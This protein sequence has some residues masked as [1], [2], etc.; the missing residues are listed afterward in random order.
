M[1]KNTPTIRFRVY[2]TLVAGLVGKDVPQDHAPS[3]KD[4]AAESDLPPSWMSLAQ[5]L[6][7]P[8]PETANTA[9]GNLVLAAQSSPTDRE[10]WRGLC[11][12]VAMAADGIDRH[13]RRVAATA[14]V[15]LLASP[16]RR[17][18]ATEPI[19]AIM[20]DPGHPIHLAA[21]A[22]IRRLTDAEAAEI[23]WQH[24]TTA[25]WAAACRARLAKIRAREDHEPPAHRRLHPL[26]F[27]GIV[28][29]ES[30][31]WGERAPRAA[32]L[33]EDSDPWSDTDAARIVARRMLRTN[34]GGLIE[35][36]AR[37]LACPEPAIALHAV[38]WTARLNLVREL[39]TDLC[40][41]ARRELA[42]PSSSP[43]A[44]AVAV[45]LRDAGDPESLDLLREMMRSAD[46]RL[47]ASAM[48]SLTRR[49]VRAGA[50]TGVRNDLVRF[51]EDDR[52]RVR[53]TAIWLWARP[54]PEAASPALLAMLTDA[55][56]MHRVAAL[57]ATERLLRV[58]MIKPTPALWGVLGVAAESD[59]VLAVRTRA[60][61]C[62]P[63]ASPAPRV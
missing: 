34:P 41:L 17:A 13:R 31:T 56:A 11:A 21:R 1:V 10:H 6:E 60:I 37:R 29:H 25:P 22:A 63:S 19:R 42:L 18:A 47:C 39:S 9:A 12:A 27:G 62:L 40:T 45:A 8:D 49:A 48:E 32:A 14:L 36:A 26:R 20:A 58:G 57:W 7:S 44:A 24:Q 51:V 55:A 30:H 52:H 16:V 5:Q 15:V 28:G 50:W 54:E 38:R 2:R 3:P 35:E 33:R 4:E 59:R 23:A 43:L 53:A 46:A 61:R